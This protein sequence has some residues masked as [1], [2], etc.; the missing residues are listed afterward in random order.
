MTSPV[1][2]VSPQHTVDE[3]LTMMTEHHFRHLPVLQGDTVVG[4]ISIGDLVKWVISDQAHTIQALE[5]YIT[6]RIRD[7]R[8]SRIHDFKNLPKNYFLKGTGFSPYV[9][10]LFLITGFSR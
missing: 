6:A 7:R 2:S 1:V 10:S 3:C 9:E 8:R 4:M 5:G